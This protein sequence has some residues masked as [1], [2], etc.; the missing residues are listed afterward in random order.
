MKTARKQTTSQTEQS[1]QDLLNKIKELEDKN[2]HY[3]R[4]ECESRDR[5]VRLKD[6]EIQKLLCERQ[7]LQKEII[8]LQ[9]HVYERNQELEEL[10]QKFEASK[11][12]ADGISATKKA[13]YEMTLSDLMEKYQKSNKKQE[14]IIHEKEAKIQNSSLIIDSLSSKNQNDASVLVVQIE[15]LRD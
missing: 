12:V 6:E 14:E 5:E 9:Q 10:Q 8:E 2:M 13:Q 11:A 4:I 3:R 1:Y 7:D 15:Q